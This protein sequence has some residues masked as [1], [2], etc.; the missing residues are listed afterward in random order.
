M[1]FL[2]VLALAPFAALTMLPT[3]AAASPAYV[4]A[5]AEVFECNA[6]SGCKRIPG[7][8]ANLP[9]MVTLNTKEKNLFSGLFGGEGLLQNGDVYEDEKVLIL[10]GRRKLQTWTAV[11]NKDTGAMSGSISQLDR[12]YSQFGH[13]TP[14]K[15]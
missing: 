6:V 9:P 2:R 1:R 14:S 11:V 12:T 7:K 8:V 5:V 13:C 15:P 3:G 4:C 10:R